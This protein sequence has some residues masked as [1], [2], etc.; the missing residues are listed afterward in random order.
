MCE[1]NLTTSI[2]HP[3]VAVSSS[4]STAMTGIALTAPHVSQ[5]ATNSHHHHNNHHHS[6]TI[7]QHQGYASSTLSSTTSSH[8][9]NTTNTNQLYQSK[10]K[11]ISPIIAESIKASASL[12]A[13]NTTELFADSPNS[14]VSKNQI[15]RMID[16]D[17]EDNNNTNFND[18]SNDSS[19]LP[20]RLDKLDEE[21]KQ[22]QQQQTLNTSISAVYEKNMH[23][24][25]FK[26]A[27][28]SRP[29]FSS[30]F[31]S[32][33]QSEFRHQYQNDIDLNIHPSTLPKIVQ[34]T[35]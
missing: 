35:Q 1:R 9:N 12:S 2:K 33:N 5:Q 8:T 19:D 4:T 34:H 25:S 28:S 22:Q 17:N 30:N 16:T 21:E 13:S 14:P 7:I 26:T 15:I 29:L 11:S 31:N 23:P 24:P 3:T 6:N 18:V 32:S 10:K 20:I 27:L